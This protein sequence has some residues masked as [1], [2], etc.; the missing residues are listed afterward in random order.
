VVLATGGTAAT[1][2]AP[3][4]EVS[5]SRLDSIIIP[6]RACHARPGTACTGP[7]RSEFCATRDSDTLLAIELLEEREKRPAVVA[8]KKGEQ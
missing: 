8:R 3:V 7:R 5:M 1:G 2:V 4:A 6:C